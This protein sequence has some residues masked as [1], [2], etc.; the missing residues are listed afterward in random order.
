MKDL[1]NVLGEIIRLWDGYCDE[2]STLEE[3]FGIDDFLR[4]DRIA[5]LKNK[6]VP[7]QELS[8]LLDMWKDDIVTN[9]TPKCS[10]CGIKSRKVV[11]QV[12]K[13]ISAQ[14]DNHL[15]RNWGYYCQR[16]YDVGSE[17]EREAM[18]G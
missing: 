6:L 15:P 5:P 14:E 12:A 11:G 17:L 18:Y 3:Y 10:F 7:K 9:F 2:R 1:D 4:H 8:R 13:G 16:C